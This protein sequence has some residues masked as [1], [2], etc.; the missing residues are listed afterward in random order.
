MYR[1]FVFVSQFFFLLLCWI[2]TNLYMRNLITILLLWVI[3][4]K[5][6]YAQI[7]ESLH[8]QILLM[9]KSAY[10]QNDDLLQ[11]QIQMIKYGN[12]K[13]ARKLLTKSYKSGN[14]RAACFIAG[15]YLMEDTTSVGIGKA[16][17]WLQKV[18]DDS[19]AVIMLYP[20]YNDKNCAFYDEA[21]GKE[22]IFRAADMG[23]AQ[24]LFDAGTLYLKGERGVDKDFD[25]AMEYYHSAAL[26]YEPR[27]CVAMATYLLKSEYSDEESI[28]E[29]YHYACVAD[30]MGIAGARFIIG[31]IKSMSGEQY[32]PVRAAAL[33]FPFAK[34]GNPEA[35]AELGRLMMWDD[36]VHKDSEQALKY[37]E[38]SAA[39]GHLQAYYYLAYYYRYGKDRNLELAK[40][41]IKYCYEMAPDNFDYRRCYAEI[42]M[43]RLD[44]FD[45]VPK[46]NGF[47]VDSVFVDSLLAP[48]IE[49]NDWYTLNYFVK[50]YIA[51]KR[52]PEAYDMAARTRYHRA[53][54]NEYD[55][56][57][58]RQLVMR[59][60]ID[61]PTSKNIAFVADRAERGD[62]I[63]QKVLGSYYYRQKK[64]SKARH[65]YE[66]AVKQGDSCA[67]TELK[68]M[69]ELLRMK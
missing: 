56:D 26:K 3:L 57:N 48:G 53:S 49:I 45:G 27:A 62:V 67:K 68:Y 46:T 22:Y 5:C 30:S 2:K 40:K 8:K 28:N 13:K 4:P 6:V 65:F 38:A 33:L 14:K 16:M 63:A 24:A 18:P 66:L 55:G 35:M 10:E 9:S 23:D 41:N 50:R 37:F 29:A 61:N 1:Y 36:A 15:S 51:Q 25:K 34:E 12:M 39:K 17:E 43:D 58:N 47:K 20:I 60:M 32:D 42:L 52:F 31:I 7:D 59:A 19:L 11:G 44:F 64:Y 69:N 54:R 21:K